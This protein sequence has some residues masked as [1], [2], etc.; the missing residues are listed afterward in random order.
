M[1]EPTD[2]IIAIFTGVLATVAIIQAYFLKLSYK[3]YRLM[4]RPVVFAYLRDAR[5]IPGIRIENAGK[6]VAWNGK[7]SV[8]ALTSKSETMYDFTRL[9]EQSE[10][11][12]PIVG[13]PKLQFD[14]ERDKKIRIAISYEDEERRG[15]RYKWE[16]EFALHREWLQAS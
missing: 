8:T 7:I 16:G 3:A 13:Q 9:Y 10:N 4:S 12:H 2:V 1:V 5:D 11:I 6:G 14:P 15:N